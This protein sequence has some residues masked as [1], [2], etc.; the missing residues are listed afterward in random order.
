MIVN[1]RQQKIAICIL[2]LGL[3]ITA[4]GPTPV[5]S[6]SAGDSHTCSLNSE[7]AVKCWGSNEQGQLGNGTFEQSAVPVSVGGLGKASTIAAGGL[8]T[9]ALTSSGGV[10]CWGSNFYG[11]LGDGTNANHTTPVDVRG[12]T[13]GVTALA[14]GYNHS[15]ALNSEGGVKCWG[16][17]G[18]GQLGDGSITTTAPYGNSLPVDVSGLT[19]GV[20][21]IAAGDGHTCALTTSGGV[22]CWGYN[23]HGQLGSGAATTTAP[24]AQPTPVDVSGLTSGVSAIVAGHGQTCAVTTAGSVKCWGTNV[25]GE[26]GDGTTENRAAPV[27][28][29]GLE[30]G[31][32]AL[33]A[34]YEHTCALALNGSVRCWGG[35]RWGDISN[36]YNTYSTAPVIVSGLNEIRV[37]TAGHG[38]TCVLT[39]S[40]TVKCWGMNTFGQLGD[41]T[42][43][44][45]ATPVDVKY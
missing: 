39:S 5:I 12:L 2:A 31:I 44:D 6:I 19:S 29:L 37:V 3:F 35:G 17:N 1:A 32:G 13:S 10:K 14:V 30:S 36:P 27:N 18:Y 25:Y 16:I 38:H 20:T 26:L 34:G 28:T 22:K 8:H 40:Q 21:A 24:F 4:C 23:Q 7:G 41:G 33:A 11:Q 45:Q 43:T 15:C 9:C 42:T